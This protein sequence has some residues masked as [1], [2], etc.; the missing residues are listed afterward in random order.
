MEVLGK[1][2]YYSGGE[3]LVEVVN[4]SK[5][6]EEFFMRGIEASLILRGDT[7]RGD[8]HIGKIL[9][10]LVRGYGNKVG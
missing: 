9:A 10:R 1:E 4:L 3:D 8:I 5:C 2:R 7:G 6:C